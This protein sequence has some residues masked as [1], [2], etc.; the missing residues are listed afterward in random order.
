MNYITNKNTTRSTML[1]GEN[2]TILNTNILSMKKEYFNKILIEYNRIIKMDPDYSVIFYCDTN[3][4]KYNSEYI[5]TKKERIDIMHNIIEINNDNINYVNIIKSK[6][7]EPNTKILFDDFIMKFI[8]EENEF[9]KEI[10]KFIEEIKK[11][12]ITII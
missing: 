8:D 10:S 2:I 7:F 9:K 3:N 11:K 6:H 4:P 5:K 12:N 1:L